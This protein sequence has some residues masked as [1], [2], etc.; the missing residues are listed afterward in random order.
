M[1]ICKRNRK[2]AAA[3][4]DVIDR[5]SGLRIRSSTT[6]WSFRRYLRR[7]ST[8]KRATVLLQNWQ[9][10]ILCFLYA[11]SFAAGTDVIDRVSGL[12]IRSSTTH[13]SFRR[14][15]RRKSTQKRATVLLQNWQRPILCF[16]YAVSFAALADCSNDW[17]CSC[18]S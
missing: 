5:V 15:L 9:R 16:L 17:P 10:P 12:R 8:Q 18:A 7:K 3:G 11:V 1:R 14:Y 4:T 2:L 6:H 13:W